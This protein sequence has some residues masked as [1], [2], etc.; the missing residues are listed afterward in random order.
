MFLTSRPFV[1]GSKELNVDIVL[2]GSEDNFFRF[3]FA[4]WEN[5]RQRFNY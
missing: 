5:V 1:N 4:G 3:R 2:T